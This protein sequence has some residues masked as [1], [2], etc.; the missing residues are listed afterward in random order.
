MLC[1][2]ATIFY[3]FLLFAFFILRTFPVNLDTISVWY[4]PFSILV[5]FNYNLE[6]LQLTLGLNSCQRICCDVGFIH[7]EKT[8]IPARFAAQHSKEAV[9]A[10]QLFDAEID[11]R[12][13]VALAVAFTFVNFAN[14]CSGYYG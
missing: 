5:A 3:F 4:N 8:P 11:S 13:V 14:F 10:Q 1:G 9:S 12:K 6:L 7:P 2:Y